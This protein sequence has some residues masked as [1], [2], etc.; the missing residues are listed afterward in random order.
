MTTAGGA[1]PILADVA[2][3]HGDGY[4]AFDVSANGTL[5]RLPASSFEAETELVFATRAGIV[6]PALPMA[7]RY[8]HPS[9]SPDG[10][11]IAVDLKP[12]GAGADI[13]VFPVGS[14]RGTRITDHPGQEFSPLWTPDGR[15][16]IY[17]SER[18][19]YDIWRRL[20]DASEPPRAVIGGGYDRLPSSVSPD[21]R[22]VAYVAV[23]TGIPELMTARLQGDPNEQ[24]YLSGVLNSAKPVF[25]P[26][27]RWMAYESEESGR[28]EVYVQSYPEL[29]RGKWKLSGSGGSEP[30][31]TR[32]GRE[33]VYRE[34][35]AVMAVA[36]NLERR[37]IGT[38]QMLFRGPYRFYLD[39]TAGRSYDVARDGERFLM[40]RELPERQRRR[41]IVTLNWL[42]ELKAKASQ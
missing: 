6:Q 4:A 28:A 42:E 23:K 18:P 35:D 8:D 38:P 29:T 25:S 26:D 20:S 19:T 1:V 10:T 16:L 30:L 2:Q 32:G 39:P 33:V 7:D 9:L 12:K 3:A 14:A 40:M 31:W 36:V 37:E 17:N 24:A 21:G 22:L 27:G 11:Q 41:I 34:R 13:W 15:E 5:V